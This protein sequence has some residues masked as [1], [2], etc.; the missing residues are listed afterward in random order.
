[1]CFLFHSANITFT[2]SVFY[3]G[4]RSNWK[5]EVRSVSSWVE[6]KNCF[7]LS[8]KTLLYFLFCKS[9]LLSSNSY[10]VKS[11]LLDAMIFD[12]L[13]QSSSHHHNQAIEHFP[14]SEISS[15]PFVVKSL[16]TFPPHKQPLSCFY[17][18][19]LLFPECHNAFCH[20]A[21]WA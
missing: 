8:L 11:T 20:T 16:P 9:G 1:M 2:I 5:N 17:P 21:F 10:T 13:I 15:S 19:C 7:T 3:Q 6:W 18:Y 14:Q 4:V 12:K